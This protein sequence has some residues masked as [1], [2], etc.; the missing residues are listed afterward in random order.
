MLFPFLYITLSLGSGILLSS[1]LSVPLSVWAALTALTLVSSWLIFFLRKTFPAFVGGLLAVF[2]LGAALFSFS[3]SSLEKNPLRSYASE[4]YVDF[5]GTLYRSPVLGL[6]RDYL[7]LKVDAIRDKG[8]EEHLSGRLRVSVAHTPE[9]GKLLRLHTGDRVK[10]AARIIS[11]R[12]Y[13]NFAPSPLGR[14]L[15]TQGIH[16]RASTKSPLLVERLE[17]GRDLSWMRLISIL[18]KKLQSSIENHFSELPEGSLS[19]RGAVAEALLLGER[20]RLDPDLSRSLQEAG[21]F[22]LFAISGAHIAILSF[23]LFSLFKLIRMPLRLNYAVL[24][25]ALCFYAFLVEGRPSVT[26]AT[27][28]AVA[29]LA[30]KLIW[31]HVNLLNTLAL[32]AFFL[33]FLN[34]SNLFSLGFQLTFTATLSIILFFPRIIVHL[35]RLPLRLS[36][37]FALSLTAQLGVLPIILT[38]FHRVTFSSLVLN[39][40]AI[41]LVGLIMGAGYMF[42]AAAVTWPMLAALLAG[43]LKLLIGFLIDT[44]RLVEL[45]P[46][47]SYRIPSPPTVLVLAYFLMLGF[48]LLPGKKK[49]L[50]ALFSAGFLIL[51]LILVTYPF[52]SHSPLLKV[53][54]IDVGQ[55]DSILVEFPG[56]KKMLV[57]GGGIPGEAFDIG[58]NVVSPVLWHKGIKTLDY[59][60]LTH[61]HPDH[62]NGLKSVVRNFRVKEFWEAF[63]PRNNPAYAQLK[64]MLRPRTLRKRVFR[65]E[66]ISIDGVAV[67]ILH[68]QRREPVVSRV[69]NDQSLVLRIVYGRTAILLPGDIGREAEQSLVETSRIL[70]SQV[71]KSPHHGSNSSSSP[72]FLEAVRPSTV[73]LSVGK[74]NQ[75]GLPDREVMDRYRAIG[76]RIYRTDE[77][78]AV[79]IS[80]DGRSFV[81][82][83]AV[84]ARRLCPPE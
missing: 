74:G 19:P 25:L 2:F 68:P 54:F 34:P 51:L 64:E 50:A 10:V 8:R 33:L 58:E 60:V 46:F 66:R 65:G 55:G 79:E 81:F 15:D 78:G 20:G 27:I 14:Y 77:D 48:F 49:G 73:I 16:A 41:P 24:I 37:I 5:I 39:F 67:E 13:R 6:E 28:M 80:S 22:H 3:H 23:L 44:A 53:T 82:R 62:M 32:A 84:P 36:E 42:L 52:P 70:H 7:F 4:D 83:T 29:Y 12:G 61:A 26:R 30:G 72:P 17:G 43:A 18:R 56:R 1:L 40:A 69:H 21:L 63:S 75:Y 35:P 45:L 31:R 47:L 71:L 11:H 9:S 38:A 76:A 59:L 57:D